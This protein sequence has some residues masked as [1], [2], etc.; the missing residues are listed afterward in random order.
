MTLI[1]VS[2]F[3]H[4]NPK[5]R[6]NNAD[7]ALITQSGYFQVG[8]KCRVITETVISLSIFN[9]NEE[10]HHESREIKYLVI[11]FPIVS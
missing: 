7:C 3:T 10:M 9:I 11:Y 4:H 5:A 1:F 8:L 6:R 2:F